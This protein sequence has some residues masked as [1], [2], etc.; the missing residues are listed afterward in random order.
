MNIHAVPSISRCWSEIWFTYLTP[1]SSEHLGYQECTVCHF[2][3][4]HVVAQRYCRCTMRECGVV[5]D[6]ATVTKLV[7]ADQDVGFT[8]VGQAELH[9]E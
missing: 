3:T 1:L 6:E 9:S 2:A 7:V 4:V 8:R 5:G